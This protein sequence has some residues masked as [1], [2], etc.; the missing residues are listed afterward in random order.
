MKDT[1]VKAENSY[2]EQIN[3]CLSAGALD[4]ARRLCE[5]WIQTGQEGIEKYIYEA[6]ILYQMGEEQ[7]S[8]RLILETLQKDC[9]NYELYLMRAQHRQAAGDAEHASILYQLAL[10]LCTDNQ[11]RQIIADM[12]ENC[13]TGEEISSYRLGV[14]LEDVIRDRIRMGEVHKTSEFLGKYLFHDD[15]ELG[16]IFLTENN[17]LLYMQ[18]EV[19]LC[20]ENTGRE[21]DKSAVYRFDLATF[22]QHYTNLKFYIRRVWFG[23]PESMRALCSYMEKH[24]ISVDML[25]VV[26]K[27]SV[28]DW[29]FSDMLIKL[30]DGLVEEKAISEEQIQLLENYAAFDHQYGKKY[31]GYIFWTE[32]FTK[33]EDNQLQI[34]H[35]NYK[36]QKESVE[37]EHKKD[38]KKMAFIFCSNDKLY[39][40]EVIIYLR[41][42]IIPK[43]W[44][45]EVLVVW[46]APGMAAAYNY[47]MNRSNAKYKTYMHHDTF[48]IHPAFIQDVVAMMQQENA[49][50]MLGIAGC[51]KLEADAVWWKADRDGLCMTCYQEAILTMLASNSLAEALS[52]KNGNK[53]SN[54]KGNK[55]GNREGN[56]EDNREGNKEDQESAVKRAK[57]EKY[58]KQ[59]YAPVQSLDGILLVT[60]EDIRWREDLFDGWHFYDI[61]QGLEF[62]RNGL[63]IGCIV[64]T[65]MWVLHETTMRKD[66]KDT[67]EKYRQIFLK[68]YGTDIVVK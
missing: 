51:E 60:K 40:E 13:G 39:S 53:E 1:E 10:F 16:R 12:A 25:V 20:N 6:E 44:T 14:A 32:Q 57:F 46:N 34:T 2:E 42:L 63:Q 59:G 50:A 31:A 17:L 3:I 47:A 66:P 52:D 29:L 5:E 30:H 61:S 65:D 15:Q 37:V 28:P 26:T 55:E 48:L 43:G 33:C 36:E 4:E 67:Y 35:L 24:D 62:A 9:N 49:P 38:S 68:E 45:A 23:L 22:K 11:D 27:Y 56:K 54:R 7:K 19:T 18:L 21:H 41:H 64:D 58:Q 8:D